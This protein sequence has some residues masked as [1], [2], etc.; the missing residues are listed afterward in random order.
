VRRIESEW[1]RERERERE[2]AKESEKGR[3]VEMLRKESPL[4]FADHM[5]AFTERERERKIPRE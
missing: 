2:R 5:I 3:E 1:K 4:A